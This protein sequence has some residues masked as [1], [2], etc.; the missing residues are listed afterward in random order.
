MQHLHGPNFMATDGSDWSIEFI[1]PCRDAGTT[2]HSTVPTDY[3]GNSRIGPYDIGAYEVQ[4][5]RWRSDA[6][7]PTSWTDSETGNKV[8]IRAT[9]YYRRYSHSILLLSN[10]ATRIIPGTIQFLQEIVDT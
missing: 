10:Y 2:T 7:N 5:S 8:C 6:T 4:Y 9:R 1:S 3:I